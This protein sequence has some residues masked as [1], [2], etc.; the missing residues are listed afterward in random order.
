MTHIKTV[1][2]F[3]V[4][5]LHGA[6][7][8]AGEAVLSS[9]Y[10]Q[11]KWSESGKQGCTSDHAGYVIFR[12]NRTL[13]TGHGQTV[14]A[15]GFWELGD[16]TVTLH[17]LVSPTTGGAAHPFYQARYYY[18][19]MSPKMLNMRSDGFDYTHDTAAQAGEKK[20]LTRCQ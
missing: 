3:I 13:E 10:L 9:D 16:D 18:Q 12:N 20:T 7:S 4:L 1:L 2:F 19:Y 14:S 11:G 15:V 8:L 5:T 17:L 6:T